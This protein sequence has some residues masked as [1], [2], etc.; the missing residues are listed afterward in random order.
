MFSYVMGFLLGLVAPVAMVFASIPAISDFQRY[1][2]M[3]NM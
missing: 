2:K 3:R 1:R